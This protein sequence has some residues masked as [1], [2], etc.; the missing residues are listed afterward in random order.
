VSYQ[1]TEVGDTSDALTIDSDQGSVTLPLT[2]TAVSGA[3]ILTVS[4]NP[5]NFGTVPIGTTASQTFEVSNDGNL[6]LTIK[7]AA[8]PVGVFN[9]PTPMSEG[10]FLSPGDEL[11]QT[12]TFTPTAPGPVQAVYAITGDDGG[13]PQNVLITGTGVDDP[14]AA[15]FAQLSAAGVRPGN[16]LGGEKPIGDGNYQVFSGGTI[17]WSP[18]T[19]AHL[20]LGSILTKYKAVGGPT[21]SLG[22]PTTDQVNTANGAHNDFAK[23]GGSIYWSSST[24]AHVIRNGIRTK[25][26][27]LGGDKSV[28]G[29][30]TTDTIDTAPGAHNDFAKLGSSIYYSSAT[31]N[32]VIRG[33]I[34]TKWLA[35][36]AGKSLLGYPTSDTIDAATGAHNDFTGGSIYYS[37]ATGTHEIHGLIR[38]K[39]LSLGGAASKYGYPTSDQYAI[40]GGQRQNFQHGM[41]T[42]TGTT[43][44]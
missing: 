4:P 3:A 27:A 28:L 19:G 29:Y 13:G 12:V 32:H 38:S 9:A 14:I 21:G 37:A 18:A 8:P 10:Q 16:A 41:L 36:G 5:L 25:W 39:W 2:G 26:L 31:G 34:R 35:M 40:T 44:H 11:F 23:L 7:K 20:V 42:L 30:P 15:K 1:P 24:G 17:Y 22:F 43:V 6:G 33:G